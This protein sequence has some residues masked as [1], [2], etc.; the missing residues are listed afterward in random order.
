MRGLEGAADN[1]GDQQITA[2]ELHA[3]VLGEAKHLRRNQTPQFQ[4]DADRVLVRW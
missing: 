4:G 1:N 3:Y 2:G